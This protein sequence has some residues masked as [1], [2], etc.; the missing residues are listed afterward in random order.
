MDTFAL[1]D[2]Q[3][4]LLLVGCKGLPTFEFMSDCKSGSLQY[5]STLPALLKGTSTL[6]IDWNR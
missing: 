2:A 4:L 1:A 6:A 3:S 5:R